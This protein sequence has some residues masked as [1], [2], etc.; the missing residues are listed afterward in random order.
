MNHLW[1]SDDSCLQCNRL[2]VQNSV[3]RHHHSRRTYCATSVLFLCGWD[4]RS[5]QE[6]KC[7]SKGDYT[8]MSLLS[9]GSMPDYYCRPVERTDR[10]PN[11]IYHQSPRSSSIL[12]RTTCRMTRRLF[13][14]SCQLV[15]FIPAH[16]CR[17][18]NCQHPLC[19]STQPRN[20]S[21]CRHTVPLTDDGCSN[22][23]NLEQKLGLQMDTRITGCFTGLI[24]LVQRL[25]IPETYAP[26]LH[27]KTPERL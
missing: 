3:H 25:L 24:W 5:A 17:R 8:G 20:V 16:Q 2:L 21:T 23:R 19:R 6:H 18:G 15:W 27:R 22:S 7:R 4:L 1:I 10:S 11:R 12:R 26:L 14:D 9:S 13:S